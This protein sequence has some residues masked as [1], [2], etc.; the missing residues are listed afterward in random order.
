MPDGSGDGSVMN[1][2]SSYWREVYVGDEDIPSM[3]LTIGKENIVLGDGSTDRTIEIPRKYLPLSGWKRRKL[4]E[5][6]D[7]LIDA[8]NNN[9]EEEDLY[10]TEET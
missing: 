5:F 1:L 3:V 4:H 6:L 9:K 8:A 10:G 2:W 7:D